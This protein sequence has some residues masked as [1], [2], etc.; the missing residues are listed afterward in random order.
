MFD[1]KKPSFSLHFNFSQP[2]LSVNLA[3]WFILM[4]NSDFFLATTQPIFPHSS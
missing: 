2:T 1:E 4:I 3:T